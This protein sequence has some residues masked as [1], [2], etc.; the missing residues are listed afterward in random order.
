LK[1]VPI[2]CYHANNVGG[3]DRGSNDHVALQRDLE[4][5][6]RAGRAV[7]PLRMIAEWRL[8]W[9]EDLP[10]G[11]IGLSCD[12]GSWFDWYDL[13]HPIWGLQP[14]FRRI[15]SDAQAS[16]T[17]VHM[18]SFVIVSPEA[19]AMLDRTCMI[20]R[21]WWGDEW[22]SEAE[23]GGLF[24]IE[25]HSWDHQHESLPDPAGVPRRPRGRFDG[26]DCEAWA[27][28]QIARSMRYLERVRG[29]RPSLFAFPYGQRNAWLVEDY[30]PRQAE[31]L[32]LLAAFV[33]EPRPVTRDSP[34]FELPRYVCGWHW[35][36]DDDLL[37]LL[38]D[39]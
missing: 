4:I 2:L 12:D 22:W 19:R 10:V 27:E 24:A 31:R 34:R 38:R 14:S 37:A 8:G 21:G 5:L 35:K 26:I 3:A 11:A 7:V 18:T 32:D 33:T 20:G 9:R 23:R 25:S 28:L 39:A 29:R 36:S 16:G 1:A 13:E 15:L 17:A 30:L 6:Q